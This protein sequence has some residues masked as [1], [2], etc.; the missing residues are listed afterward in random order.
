MNTLKEDKLQQQHLLERGRDES[1]T[2]EASLRLYPNKD[3]SLE[4]ED[5]HF[6]LIQ[7]CRNR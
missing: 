5:T 4:K 1:G 7:F 2:I 3:K 6:T